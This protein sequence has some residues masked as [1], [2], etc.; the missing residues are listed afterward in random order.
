MRWKGSRWVFAGTVVAVVLGKATGTTGL[1]AQES[2]LGGRWSIALELGELPLAG[3][4][5]PEFPSGTA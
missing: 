3:S 5:R 2:G 1:S 4:S